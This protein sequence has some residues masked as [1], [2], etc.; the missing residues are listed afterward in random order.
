MRMKERDFKK[1][2]LTLVEILVVVGILSLL[3]V[4]ATKL[5][6]DVFQYN[7]NI[8]AILTNIGEAR[9]ALKTMTAESRTAS[10]SSLGAYALEQTATSSFIF[11]S[12]IDTDIEKERVRYYLQNGTLMKGVTNA[13][14][15]PLVY[16]VG[17]EVRTELV[18]TVKNSSTTPLF[19]YYNEIYAG[20]TTALVAPFDVSVVRLVKM[21]ILVGSSAVASSTPSIY[22]TQVTFRNLK[23]N[24]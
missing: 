19:S 21:Q 11:Y 1:N 7:R 15:S 20:T 14:G 24:L 4:V 16:N 18:H 10:P 17:N 6:R 3:V 5:F 12:D 8:S 23:D 2:G 22:S 13:T 9:R